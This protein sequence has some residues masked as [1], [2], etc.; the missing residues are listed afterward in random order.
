MSDSLANL[1]VQE[2]NPKNF[3]DYHIA[4]SILDSDGARDIEMQ[5]S[6][7]NLSVFLTA[8]NHRRDA[9]MPLIVPVINTKH[10]NIIPYHT[11]WAEEGVFSMQFQLRSH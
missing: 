3:M 8:K 4:F 10:L 7:A 11:L 9:L 6:Q 2:C 1:V 5:F